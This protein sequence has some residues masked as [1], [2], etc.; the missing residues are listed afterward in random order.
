M[1]DYD[2]DTYRE[3][4]NKELIIMCKLLD[5]LEKSINER[6]EKEINNK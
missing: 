6:K 2:Y 3:V 5:E 1:V 4:I